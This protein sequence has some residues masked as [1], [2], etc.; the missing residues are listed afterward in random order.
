MSKGDSGIA[1]ASGRV[2]VGG[3]T[4][5]RERVGHREFG[6]H[7]RRRKGCGWIE[8]YARLK[9]EEIIREGVCARV[10]GKQN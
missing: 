8:E 5:A 7:L 2:V 1:R 6:S 3:V 10:S 9:P 4:F